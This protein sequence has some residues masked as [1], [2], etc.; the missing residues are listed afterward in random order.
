MQRGVLTAFAAPVLRTFLYSA[1]NLICVWP[2]AHAKEMGQSIEPLFKSV[3]EAVGKDKR[4]YAYL[5]LIEAIR[6]GNQRE[7]KLAADLR[8]HRGWNDGPGSVEGDA[9]DCR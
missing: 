4:L 3:P 7:S 9:D 1:G 8:S 2:H 5:A 6:I